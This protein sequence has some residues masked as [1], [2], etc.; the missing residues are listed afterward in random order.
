MPAVVVGLV[1]RDV[2]VEAPDWVADG[3]DDE[4][5]LLEQLAH[6]GPRVVLPRV[7]SPAGRDPARE[8]ARVRR[9]REEEQ[10]GAVGVDE[11]N[12]GCPAQ[13][14][15]RRHYCSAAVKKL[16]S[17]TSFVLSSGTGSTAASATSAANSLTL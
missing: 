16:T 9:G 11:H 5:R 6:G 13:A 10:G 8:A 7:H 14:R 4:P 12:S 15:R 2:E 17:P 3:V 1:P